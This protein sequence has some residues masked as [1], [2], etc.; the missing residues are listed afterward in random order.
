MMAQR[1][2]KVHVNI[3]KPRSPPE[4]QFCLY[5]HRTCTHNKL[6]GYDFCTRHILED[7]NAPY[8]QCEYSSSKNGKRCI[9][10]ATKSDKKG[11][12]RYLHVRV[13]FRSYE[14]TIACT[15]KLQYCIAVKIHWFIYTWTPF[16]LVD[17]AMTMQKKL[18]FYDKRLILNGGVQKRLTVF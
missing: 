15:S 7:K 12:H 9:N 2:P 18:F 17:T 16:T 13:R 1:Q 14:V 4:G 3:R 5:S 11:N 8:K 6:P 10:A